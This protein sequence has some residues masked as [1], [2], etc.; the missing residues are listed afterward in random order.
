[1]T[2]LGWLMIVVVIV[3]F[4]AITGVKPKGSRPVARTNL[5]SVA[6]VVLFG[7]ALLIAYLFLRQS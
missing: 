6:R 4:A 7:I 5:M 1:M 3:A 2:W